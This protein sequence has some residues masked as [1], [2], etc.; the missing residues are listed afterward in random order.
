[1]LFQLVPVEALAE[2]QT[3][4]QLTVQWV[5]GIIEEIGLIE[6]NPP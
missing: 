4:F 2:Q 1:M 3:V 5:N 6:Q